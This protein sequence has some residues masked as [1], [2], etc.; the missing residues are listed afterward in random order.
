MQNLV[1]DG[2]TIKQLERAIREATTWHQWRDNLIRMY[3]NPTEQYLHELF[4]NWTD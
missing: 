1:I 2:Y 3:Q 4:A